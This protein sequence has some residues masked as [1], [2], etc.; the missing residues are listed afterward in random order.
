MPGGSDVF[1]RAI[2]RRGPAYVPSLI[3]CPLDHFQEQ[4]SA[5]FTRIRRRVAAMPDDLL[6]VDPQPQYIVAPNRGADGSLH[7]TDHWGTG[8][9]DDGRGGK[10]TFHPLEHDFAA[11]DDYAIPDA[12]AAGDFDAADAALRDR[13]DRYVLG[14]VWFT[15]FERYWMLRGFNNALLDMYTEEDRF[16][17][18]RD[19][20]LDYALRRVDAWVARGVDGVFFSDD[21][22]SQRGLL[23]DPEVWRHHFR[24]CYRKLFERVKSGGAHV[25]MHLCGDI[26]AIL[27]DLIELGLDVLNPVQPRAM[28][29]HELS[30]DF[31][32]KV[33]FCGGAD[34]QGVLIDGPTERIRAHVD[35]LVSLFGSFKGGYILSTSHGLMPETPL[36]H[37]IALYDAALHYSKRT[38]KE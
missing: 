35:E 24:P 16:A 28:D 10:T 32:G 21:W 7:W 2:E 3:E 23:I 36:D 26:R 30:R 15:L 38:I 17:R 31:G 34:V 19:G 5:K 12:G 11:L 37:V 29:V 9:V 4:D 13:G 1:Q 18:L 33:C 22:G 8:W 14:S 6:K 27:P 20:V 25:W